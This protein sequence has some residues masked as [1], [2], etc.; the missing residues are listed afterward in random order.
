MAPVSVRTSVT[1]PQISETTIENMP[2]A[3]QKEFLDS[4]I[5]RAQGTTA[6]HSK[7]CNLDCTLEFLKK[8][9]FTHGFAS[10]S[11]SSSSSF[12]SHQSE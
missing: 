5:N 6:G 3:E 12:R 11:S 4:I 9:K 2:V 10:A 8:E 7:I 1:R